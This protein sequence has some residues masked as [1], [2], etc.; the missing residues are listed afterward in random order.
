MPLWYKLTTTSGQT[1]DFVKRTGKFVYDIDAA[2]GFVSAVAYRGPSSQSDW[3]RAVK[4]RDI[5]GKCVYRVEIFCV[6]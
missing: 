6:T 4:A 5:F 3:D 1:Y 2:S